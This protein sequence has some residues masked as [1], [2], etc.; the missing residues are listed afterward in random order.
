MAVQLIKAQR[1]KTARPG[2]FRRFCVLV[3]ILALSAFGNCSSKKHELKKAKPAVTSQVKKKQLKFRC[4]NYKDK[5]L[6]VYVE[7]STQTGKE[8]QLGKEH[9]LHFSQLRIKDEKSNTKPLAYFC[10]HA[11]FLFWVTADAVYIKKLDI[12]K[13]RL[14]VSKEKE[15]RVTHPN[16]FTEPR[17]VKVKADIWHNPDEKWEN[18]PVALISNTGFFHVARYSEKAVASGKLD[19]ANIDLKTEEKLSEENRWLNNGVESGVVKVLSSREFSIIPLGVKG[20]GKVRIGKVLVFYYV[21]F[22]GKPGVS[23]LGMDRDIDTTLLKKRKQNLENIYAIYKPP[24]F[25]IEQGGWVV[26]LLGEDRKGKTIH[27]FPTLID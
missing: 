4:Y 19:R 5:E 10:N 2:R 17:N 16:E 21:K 9:Q 25:D 1:G 26:N 12:E 13:N 7:G 11:G 6:R 22:E 23:F 15:V 3:G 20:K 14:E 18:I 8:R 27:L 24:R